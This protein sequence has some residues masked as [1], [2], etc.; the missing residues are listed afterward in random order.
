[1]NER[2]LLMVGTKKGAFVFES[3]DGKRTWRST[4]P[5]FKGTQVYHLAYDP[6][7]RSV[8]A[9][10]DSFVW[11]PTV[12]K[13]GD[14]GRTWKESK[15]PPKFPK[16]SELAVGKVWHIQPANEDEPGV[17]YCGTDPAALFRSDDGGESWTLNRGLFEHESRPKWTPGFGGLC[18]HSI[19]VDPSDP[20]TLVVAISSVGVLKST[21][22]GRSWS[23]RNKD[24]LADFMPPKHRYPVFGQCPH[25]LVRHASRPEVIY[26]QNHCGVYRS[27][28]GGESWKDIS[29]GLPSRFGFGIAVDSVDPRRIYVAPEE[30]GAARLPLD[31]RFL[32]WA[33][34]DAGRS[35]SP[36]GSG[37]PRRSYYNV[38]REG[39]ATDGD[40]PGG[41]YFGTTTGQLFGSR[42]GGKRWDLIADGL[43][44]IYSVTA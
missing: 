26:Q 10:V 6:R 3:K 33:S 16:G 23:F 29:A 25:H 14:G 18:L 35:W 13:S 20:L 24:V 19:L 44:P 34:D 38:L 9:A 42:N 37:L 41:V 22:G 17:V 4:G 8:L 28:D 15:K 36:L 1:M 27:D 40:D 32:V 30:S 11:G 39:M 5:H 31:D 7:D 12:A 21:D 2:T 43:P